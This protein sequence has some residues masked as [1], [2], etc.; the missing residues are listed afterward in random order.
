MARLRAG[1][2]LTLQKAPERASLS[3]N[4]AEKVHQARRLHSQVSEDTRA[5]QQYATSPESKSG[6]CPGEL[7]LVRILLI[8]VPLGL[9]RRL[10]LAV[11]AIVIARLI[12]GEGGEVREKILAL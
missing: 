5:G 4:L 9:V 10:S 12:L 11:V 7:W 3:N 8:I 6:V 2:W 1:W